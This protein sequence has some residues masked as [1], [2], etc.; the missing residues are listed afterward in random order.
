MTVQKRNARNKVHIQ[1]L[2]FIG[3]GVMNTAISLSIIYVGMALGV[4]YK[5][6]NMIGYI[7]GMSNS[8][9]WNKNWVF[10]SKNNIC[11]ELFWFSVSFAICY[12]IQYVL[13]LLMVDKWQWNGYLAQLLAMGTYTVSNFI[14][15]RLVTFRKK[16][17]R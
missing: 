14:L 6:A 8:F 10:G 16:T 17:D 2:K 9:I 13:L 7:A 4:N 3:V 11:K 5:L 15:N 12:A 1:F